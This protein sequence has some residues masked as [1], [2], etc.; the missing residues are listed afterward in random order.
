MSHGWFSAKAG[1]EADFP[2]FQ[3]LFVPTYNGP[4]CL[5]R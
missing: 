5:S 2:E 3:A 1:L 4:F